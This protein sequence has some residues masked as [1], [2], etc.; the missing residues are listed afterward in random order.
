MMC[1]N[2]PTLLLLRL[3]AKMKSEVCMCVCMRTLMVPHASLCPILMPTET[4]MRRV[5]KPLEALLTGHKRLVVKDSAVSVCAVVMLCSAAVSWYLL[6][7]C[8]V[9]CSCT[10]YRE[11]SSLNCTPTFALKLNKACKGMDL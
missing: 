8:R 1:S 4:Y 5:V 9:Y 6:P 10:P 3:I 11:Y 2:M 7:C